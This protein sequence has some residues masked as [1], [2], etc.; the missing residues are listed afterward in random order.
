M[1]VKFDCTLC[2]ACCNNLRVPLSVSEA[3]AWVERGGE[4]QILCDAWIPFPATGGA[5]AEAEAAERYR[6]QRSF[7]ATSESLQIRVSVTLV[8][9]FDRACPFLLDDMRCGA[10]AVRP[11][12]CRIYPAEVNPF[13]PFSPDRKQCP[14]DA[15]SAAR[16]PFLSHGQPSPETAALIASARQAAIDDMEAKAKVCAIFGLD[17][18]GFSNEGYIVHRPGAAALQA[19]LAAS[20]M[21]GMAAN[22]AVQ[23]GPDS[24][25]SWKIITNQGGTHAT[26][27]A[28]G[29]ESLYAGDRRLAPY[30]YVG[31]YA[32][33]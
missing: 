17:A 24:A 11:R 15:W 23:P 10:Y 33:A 21:A 5:E 6:L 19:A 22:M 32:A 1:D 28:A 12:V 4:V 16:T 7:A 13:V 3:Q 20:Q 8:G 9:A 27:Q 14:P 26:L 31:F 30:E 18:A 29:V 25:I 2:G